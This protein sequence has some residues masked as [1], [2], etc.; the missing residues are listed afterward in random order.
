MRLNTRAR[1]FVQLAEL[2]T[3]IIGVGG[4]F[5]TLGKREADLVHLS[6]DVEAISSDIATLSN[7]TRDL[8]TANVRSEQRLDD[9]SRRLDLL[10]RNR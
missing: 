8:A 6:E 5:L 1:D 9:I 4:L 3:L 7:I 10:E 2:I